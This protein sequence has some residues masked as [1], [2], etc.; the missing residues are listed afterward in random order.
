MVSLHI[1]SL[2]QICYFLLY[3][4]SH[5]CHFFEKS[6]QK[7]SLRAFSFAVSEASTHTL[8]SH[9]VNKTKP[10]VLRRK[11]ERKYPLRE[12]FK[13]DTS[14]LRE[15]ILKGRHRVS[16]LAALFVLFCPYRKVQTQYHFITNQNQVMVSLYIILLTKFDVLYYTVLR[17]FALF[18]KKGHKK[19][20]YAHFAL[21][22]VKSQSCRRQSFTRTRL[23]ALPP[24]ETLVPQNEPLF[25]HKNFLQ[26]HY[27]QFPRKYFVQF[28]IYS[29]KANY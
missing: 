9:K 13:R 25:A 5:L 22:Q 4:A 29:P 1:I 17:T 14:L 7:T 2:Y 8:P 21:R 23:S 15:G 26:R 12:G 24:F 27:I 20:L 10:C 3:G 19:L 11:L 16:P 6:G 18:C 28:A